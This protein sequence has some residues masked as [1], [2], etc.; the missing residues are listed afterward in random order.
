MTAKKRK[1]SA[2]VEEGYL[3]PLLNLVLN[4][5]IPTA[6]PS[7]ESLGALLE[8]LTAALADHVSRP[9]PI[10][11]RTLPPQLRPMIRWRPDKLKEETHRRSLLLALQ[12][13]QEFKCVNEAIDEWT[14]KHPELAKSVRSGAIYAGG[15]LMAAL[16]SR[17]PRT[18]L[19]RIAS[20][21]WAEGLEDEAR[22]RLFKVLVGLHSPVPMRDKQVRS[23]DIDDSRQRLH[24]QVRELRQ[25]IRDK[26]DQIT[27]L[28][29]AGIKSAERATNLASQLAEAEGRLRTVDGGRRDLVKKVGRLGDSM[30]VLRKDWEKAGRQ[31]VS[32]SEEVNSLSSR[33]KNATE[34]ETSLMAKLTETNRILEETAAN[35]Q[36]L[37]TG[38]QAV[39]AYIKEQEAKVNEELGVAQGMAK[40]RAQ[41][42]HATI[43]KLERSFL[44][45]R[46]EFVAPRPPPPPVLI[47]RGPIR[48]WGLGGADEIGGSAYLLEIGG[49]RILI[50][51][52]SR[53]GRGLDDLGPSLGEI[54]WLDAVVLTHAHTDH[55]GWLPALV[56]QT[57][58]GFEMFATKATHDLIRV[59]LEDSLKQLRMLLDQERLN[60]KH[61]LEPKVVHEPYGRDE[62]DY[63][64]RW[65]SPLDWHQ[66]VGLKGGVRISLHHAGHILGAA[67]VLVEGDGRKVVVT[68]DFA[69]FSQLTVG[70]AQWPAEFADADL[71][72]MESTYGS[73]VHPPRD[74]EITD[75]VAQVGAALSGGGTALIPSFAWGRAQEVL[76]ILNAAMNHGDLRT[77]PVW[78]HG[79][80]EKINSEYRR[81]GWPTLKPNF[82]ECSRGGYSTEDVIASVSREPSIIVTTSGML[83]GGPGVEYAAKLLNNPRN[84]LFFTGYQDEESPGRA[85]LN[86]TGPGPHTLTIPNEFGE[87]REVR[88]AAP[89]KKI[90][91]SAH[92]DQTGLVQAALSLFPRNIVLVHG[93]EAQRKALRE[94]LTTKKLQVAASSVEFDTGS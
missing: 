93:D 56:R 81:Y 63:V 53:V 77:S 12:T 78:I 28:K 16:A 51:C 85:M 17:N 11:A 62:V 66:E 45:L 68:G 23:D 44:A 92:A 73:H 19:A 4:G 71:L 29:G 15:E 40:Q 89:A 61:A 65:L 34:R 50:D 67:S 52:G 58:G 47:H 13:R 30:S 64:L 35:L 74:K 22:S 25:D 76:S 8:P 1:V 38:A 24:Q 80:V 84:R 41:D 48:Y 49:K 75:L 87:G 42:E 88:I 33:L 82:T 46:P 55:V 90:N 14:L 26:N 9:H 31:V 43:R 37:P 60:Q 21:L 94:R 39:W 54:D 2:P 10:A 59:M 20:M 6:L 3:L 57:G 36:A 70:A 83:A 27:A 86:L 18:A 7:E 72:I 79:M 91:L 69:D 32:A 5:S